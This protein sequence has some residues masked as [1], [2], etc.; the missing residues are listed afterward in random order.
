MVSTW[1]SFSGERNWKASSQ[2]RNQPSLIISYLGDQDYS[3]DLAN[4]PPTANLSSCKVRACEQGE[5]WQQALDLFVAEQSV[6]LCPDVITCKAS[7]SACENTEQWQ[8]ALGLP[9]SLDV[10]PNSV[11]YSAAISAC[12]KG[13]QWQQAL[14][15]FVTEQSVKL[16]PDVVACIASIS[17]REKREQWQQAAFVTAFTGQLVELHLKSDRH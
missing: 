13:E 11:T 12:E 17:A 7:I 9:E 4:A 5:Q 16:L 6:E 15:L 8:Q 1:S 14:D 3:Q 2:N 10:F